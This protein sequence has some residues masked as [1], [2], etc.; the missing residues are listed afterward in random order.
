[1]S[2]RARLAIALVTIYLVWGSTYLAIAIAV[3][4]I[5]PLS[6]AAVRFLTAGIVLYA[7]L[8]AR[9]TEAPSWSETRTAAI[10]GVFL[11]VG[12]NG[13]VTTNAHALP[14]GIVA[15]LIATTPLFMVLLPILFGGEKPRAVTIAA[16]ALGLAGVGALVRPSGTEAALPMMNVLGIICAA[17]SWSIGSLI[18]KR[19]PAPASSMMAT[20]QQ[21]TIGGLA[22]VVVAALRGELAQIELS[23]FST[24]SMLALAYLTIFGSVTGFGAYVWLL[25]N[26]SPAVAT[27]YAYVNPLVALLLGSVLADEPFGPRT[28]LAG[29]LIIGAVVLL[30]TDAGRNQR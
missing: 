15:L 10:V 30:V 7:A 4:T 29:A 21:M 23:A 13:L 24:D 12:G 22:L 9:G 3:R 28:V 11:L 17:L 18:S 5:P 19:M 14:S 1:M 27:S 20:A 26:T 16:T 2:H 8:R 25:R 6:M